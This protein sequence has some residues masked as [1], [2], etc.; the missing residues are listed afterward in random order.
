MKLLIHKG[1]EQ[2]ARHNLIYKNKVGECEILKDEISQLKLDLE[3]MTKK[4]Q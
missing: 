2:K 3:E 1:I 4:R